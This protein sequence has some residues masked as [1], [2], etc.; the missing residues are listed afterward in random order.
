MCVLNAII[1]MILSKVIPKTGFPRGRHGTRFLTPGAVRNAK[2]SRQ[3]KA[4]SGPLMNNILF[5]CIENHV[6]AGM[7]QFF[8]F[9]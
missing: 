2:F 6:Q 5:S 8:W 4:F 3:K 7:K 9:P 1:F